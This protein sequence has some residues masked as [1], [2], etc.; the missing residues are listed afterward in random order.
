MRPSRPRLRH[1]R[2]PQIARFRFDI[3]SAPENKTN[4]LVYMSGIE[5][6]MNDWMIFRFGYQ[7]NNVVSKNYIT[8]GAGFAGPQ[9]G[10]HYAYVS[11]VADKK[12]DKHSI[13]LG[14]PF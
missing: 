5:T 9:F 14:I 6:Y 1:N 7:N 10:L 4:R 13:D 3:E 8:A 2:F 12:E 11:N